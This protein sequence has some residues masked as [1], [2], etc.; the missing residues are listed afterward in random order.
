MK[1]KPV[2]VSLITLVFLCSCGEKITTSSSGLSSEE[3]TSSSSVSKSSSSEDTDSTISIAEARA[4][5]VGEIVTIRGIVAKLNYTGQATPEVCGFWIADETG[6]IYVYGKETAKAVDE[7]DKVA[8]SGKKT[9][10]IPD[11]D[12]AAANDTG[13]QGMLQLT[14]VTLIDTYAYDQAIPATAITTTTIS[15]INRN[16]SITE[17]KTGC[18]YQ[19]KGTWNRIDMTSFVN[20][21]I[22]DPNQADSLLAYTQCNGKDYAWTDEEDGKLVTLT[23][24]LTL[25]KPGVA[26]WRICPISFA[27]AT[28]A[29]EAEELDYA[30]VRF[31]DLIPSKSQGAI[32][33]DIP[34]V[35]EKNTNATRSMT[36]ADSSVSITS[37]ETTLHVSIPASATGEHTLSLQVKIGEQTKQK[38]VTVVIKEAQTFDTIT[39]AKAREQEDGTKVTVT[40]IIAKM[41]YKSSMTKQGFFLV[42]STSSILVFVNN[43]NL[44]PNIVDLED[45]MQVT[46][47]GT[48]THYQPSGDFTG[49]CQITDPTILS[50]DSMKHAIPTNPT[51]V[52]K[53]VAE[54]LATPA[55]ENITGYVFEVEGYLKKVTTPHY[56]NYSLADDADGATSIT[57][58][59]QNTGAAD[60]EYL[61]RYLDAKHTFYYGVNNAKIKNNSVTWRGTIV[62]VI[63]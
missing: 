12:A 21:Q 57:L 56:T 31:T 54:I 27:A 62:S 44:L 60:Y 24:V 35:D 9:Y 37:D 42:D 51:I 50:H 39:I 63:A 55:T 6:S 3:K 26:K 14:D 58:Y 33:L 7:G 30:M 17:D 22:V 59:S 28:P 38:D 10:Y 47:E 45:G 61:D 8:L 43:N 48:F 20:Y 23:F 4:A 15:D 46:L 11:T 34:L 5:K 18:I 49:N 29:T 1:R 52:K 36:T 41:T 13:Y 16:L 25:A 53:T 32:G 40:G 19:A 2:V